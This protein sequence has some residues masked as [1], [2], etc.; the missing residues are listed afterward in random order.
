MLK[1]NL[2]TAKLLDVL[3]KE[4]CFLCRLKQQHIENY[5]SELI[6][7]CT[8]DQIF[9]SRFINSLGF[10][11]E[12]NQLLIK[13]I[14]K[15]YF[16]SRSSVAKLYENTI[17]VYLD[18]LCLDIS[19]NKTAPLENIISHL[20]K[21]KHVIKSRNKNKTGQYSNCMCCIASKKET[22]SNMLTLIEILLDKD[23]KDLYKAGD[24]L[25][26]PHFNEVITFIDDNGVVS[27]VKDFLINDHEERLELL[28]YRLQCLQEKKRYDNKEILSEAEALSW[29]EAIWRFSGWKPDNLLEIY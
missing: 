3:N 7:E 29:H 28:H 1:E 11:P 25:C 12:H 4:K 20:N 21:I 27:P 17:P 8:T 23:C 9:I 16:L 19:H 26:I 6:Y 22:N 2:I 5:I 18:S 14:K 15:N 13:L 24:G 10:C